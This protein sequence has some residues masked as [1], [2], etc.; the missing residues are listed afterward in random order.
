MIILIVMGG[1]CKN[2]S[3]NVKDDLVLHRIQ[4]Y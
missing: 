4:V 1:V 2:A 3:N